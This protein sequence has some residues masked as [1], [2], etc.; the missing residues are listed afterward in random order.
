MKFKWTNVIIANFHSLEEHAV[1]SCCRWKNILNNERLQAA[2]HW[3]C[4]CEQVTVQKWTFEYW[5]RNLLLA[6]CDWDDL[7]ANVGNT[8]VEEKQHDLDIPVETE[9]PG[10]RLITCRTSARGCLVGKTGGLGFWREELAP[11]KKGPCQDV[12]LERRTL[13]GS[14]CKGGKILEI[15]KLCGDGCQGARGPWSLTPK[16]GGSGTAGPDL[17]FCRASWGSYDLPAGGTRRPGRKKGNK[18]RI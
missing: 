13:E 6:S 12:I 18:C 7:F 11:E 8:R 9:L 16:A 17:A 10:R 3:V 5:S 4:M 15:R 1:E 2:D 14:S